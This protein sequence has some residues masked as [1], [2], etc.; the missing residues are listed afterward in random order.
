MER[1]KNES[2]S[3]LSLYV[4]SKVFLRSFA[5]IQSVLLAKTSVSHSGGKY[6]P[7]SST[8]YGVRCAVLCGSRCVHSVRSCSPLPT[9]C[10]TTLHRC[11]CNCVAL[12]CSAVLCC[13][14]PRLSP[15]YLHLSG[16]VSAL[17]CMAQDLTRHAVAIVSRL[18]VSL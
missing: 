2:L 7:L 15:S 10:Y 14:V 6:T 1:Q 16:K 17:L 4:L 5:A 9:N 13:A 11:L 8:F 18:S 3:L 12:L